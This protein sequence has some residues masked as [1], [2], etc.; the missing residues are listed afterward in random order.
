MK[1]KFI[2]IKERENLRISILFLM[3]IT[4]NWIILSLARIN[5]YKHADQ[6]K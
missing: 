6:A 5:R 2:I 4:D 3:K 1:R